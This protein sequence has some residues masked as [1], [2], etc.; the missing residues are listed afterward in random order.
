L[1]CGNI[2]TTNKLG[3]FN[4]KRI[5]D[6]QNILIPLFDKFPLNGI[7]YLDYLTF[8]EAIAIKFDESLSNSEKLQLITDLK[9]SMNTKRVNFKMPSTHTIRVTPY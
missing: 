4:V 8:K 5:N 2:Y 7:K 9:D 6:I 3:T 1:N